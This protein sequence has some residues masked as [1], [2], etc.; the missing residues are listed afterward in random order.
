MHDHSNK[1][2]REK[3]KRK[4]LF[5]G[6]NMQEVPV[7]EDLGLGLF[8]VMNLV[9]V[10]MYMCWCWFVFFRQA[11]RLDELG[12]EIAGIAFPAALALMADPIASLVDTAF[13]GHIGSLLLASNHAS[14]LASFSIPLLSNLLCH[15]LLISSP[16]IRGYIMLSKLGLAERS[17]V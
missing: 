16:F 2:E 8:W 9:C 5:L 13:I 12:V 7:L 4:N 3:K 17:K 1:S 6:L 15:V 10:Y 14:F 11:F